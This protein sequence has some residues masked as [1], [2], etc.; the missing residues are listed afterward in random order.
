MNDAVELTSHPDPFASRVAENPALAG[1]DFEPAGESLEAAVGIT[2]EGASWHQ[3]AWA[4]DGRVAYVSGMNV[5]SV[6]WDTDDHDPFDPR[7]MKFMSTEEERI[8]VQARLALSDT[9]PRKDYGIRVAGPG[10]L[11]VDAIIKARWDLGRAAG[12]L[13]AEHTTDWELLPP[14][15]EPPGGVLLQV[16]TTQPE[17]MGERSILE[18]T[19]K[20]IRSARDLIYIEDQ[21][22]RMPVLLDAFQEALDASPELRIVVVTQPV[23]ILDGAKK[24][25]VIMDDALREMAGDRYLLLGMESYAAGHLL[26]PEELTPHFQAMN[27]HSKMLIVDDVYLSVGSC[28]KNNRG[29]LIEGE[30]NVAVVDEAFVRDARQRI[31]ANATG[32][33]DLDWNR[34]GAAVAADLAGIA[35]SNEEIRAEALS[36]GAVPD[37]EPSGFLYPLAHTPDY[38]LDIGPD[39]F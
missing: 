39:I 28:N 20:A 9:S 12:D 8:A 33:V 38:L 6:D 5:K 34:S 37:D 36:S 2:V 25:T 27:V 15:A 30:M 31:L 13:Y 16:Q 11:D 14:A 22:F 23:S 17:P 1:L 19:D 4:V 24:W 21:Y 18:S 32:R 10:A 3:K 29:L 7:R 35:E 26:D